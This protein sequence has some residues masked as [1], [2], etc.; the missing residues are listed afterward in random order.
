M[1]VEQEAHHTNNPAQRTSYT[2]AINVDASNS[3]VL[4]NNSPVV[5][6]TAKQMDSQSD[7]IGCEQLSGNT[8]SK[9]EGHRKPP[10]TIPDD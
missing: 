6:P 4:L 9:L 8:G 10:G 3:K 7:T 2:S 5:N 1:A